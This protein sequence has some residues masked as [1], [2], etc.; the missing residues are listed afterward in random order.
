MA[1]KNLSCWKAIDADG[2]Y[3]TDERD[4]PFFGR[5]RRQRLYNAQCDSGY[6]YLNGKLVKN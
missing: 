4:E 5:G 2:K 1:P 6:L 3:L